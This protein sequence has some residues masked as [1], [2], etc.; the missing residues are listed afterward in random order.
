MVSVR[1]VLKLVDDPIETVGSSSTLGI[2]TKGSCTTGVTAAAVAGW[3]MLDDR[4]ASETKVFLKE[5]SSIK[6]FYLR[7]L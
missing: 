1:L 7:N 3:S 4:L 6:T 2:R 5:T